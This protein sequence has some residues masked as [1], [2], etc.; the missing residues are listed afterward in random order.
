MTGKPRG[1]EHGAESR[2]K[3]EGCSEIVVTRPR[4]VAARWRDRARSGTCGGWRT[5]IRLHG[6]VR[7]TPSLH[8][9]PQGL[10]RRRP[11]EQVE[12]IRIQPDAAGHLGAY[13]TPGC[14]PDIWVPTGQPDAYRTPGCFPDKWAVRRG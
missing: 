10:E 2:Q 6:N 11:A 5:E 8:P 9:G 4:T 3:E 1:E 13:Q 12:G 14:L 7:T